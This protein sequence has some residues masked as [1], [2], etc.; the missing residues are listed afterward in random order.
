MHRTHV[1]RRWPVSA[2]I[3]LI[4]AAALL[5]ST[6]VLAGPEPLSSPAK[7]SA[8]ALGKAEKLVK[9]GNFREALD[10]LKVLLTKGPR[11]GSDPA[12]SNSN[13]HRRR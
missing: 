8:I 13:W 1:L 2:T 5:V 9:D 10:L 6:T 4:L 11:E 3:L 12:R 7:E